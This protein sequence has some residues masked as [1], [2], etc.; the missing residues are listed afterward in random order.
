MA[1]AA[2]EPLLR[3]LTTTSTAPPGGYTTPHA[4]A[5]AETL[6]PINFNYA[7]LQETMTAF[8][9]RFDTFLSTSR[10]RV[11]DER[12]SFKG[13]V[14]EVGDQSSACERGIVA[15]EEKA[16]GHGSTLEGQVAERG[17]MEAQISSL[18]EERDA[19]VA[20]V[21]KLR[22]Q[23]SGTKGEINTRKAALRKEENYLEGMRGAD[24]R[25]LEF[26][27]GTLG[28]RIE[29]AGS[30]DRVRFCFTG[31]RPQ[32]WGNGWKEGMMAMQDGGRGEREA[33]LTLDL[34]RGSWEVLECRPKLEQED[35][36]GCLRC[37]REGEDL[38]G[39]LRGVKGLF[40]RDLGA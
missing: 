34:S 17:E 5:P 26:W 38:R 13:R 9:R 20:M 36:E 19:R 15:L 32:K 29:G 21:Q 8:T 1:A 11:L 27:E 22:S 3:H 12:N 4:P 7:A 33:H 23:L 16:K 14:A 35:L 31:L 2:A 24:S 28:L 37:V 25:E 30:D 18:S 39:F 6:P 10:R 40:L